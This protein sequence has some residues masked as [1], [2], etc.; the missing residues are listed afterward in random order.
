[1]CPLV[2]PLNISST[3]PI[4]HYTLI[5][6]DCR[7]TNFRNYF[8]KNN[9]MWHDG[10]CLPPAN[11]WELSVSEQVLIYINKCIASLELPNINKRIA[12]KLQEENWIYFI[13]QSLA[14]RELIMWRELWL[15]LVGKASPSENPPRI[16]NISCFLF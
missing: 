6:R 15:E 2:T 14:M 5:S 3:I 10:R 9:L 7:P 12:L 13:F 11:N 8:T 1:M 16:F 4:M